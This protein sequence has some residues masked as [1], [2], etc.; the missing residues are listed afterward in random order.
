LGC[1]SS[2][3]LFIISGVPPHREL[4]NKIS[5][6]PEFDFSEYTLFFNT[7]D[8]AKI[9]GGFLQSL[10]NMAYRT[11]L[12]KLKNALEETQSTSGTC[13]LYIKAAD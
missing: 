13:L 9:A 3:N 7:N 12:K 4:L 6:L 5:Q 2:Q 8:H 1:F 11:K 10:T